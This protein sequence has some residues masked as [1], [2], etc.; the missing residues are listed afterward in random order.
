MQFVEGGFPEPIRMTHPAT[1]NVN[2]LSPHY[3]T[4]GPIGLNVATSRR[5]TYVANT[6]P[7]P[8]IGSQKGRGQ[9]CVVYVPSYAPFLGL[10]LTQLIHRRITHQLQPHFGTL[11]DVGSA[12][13]VAFTDGSC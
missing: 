13:K 8:C 11:S 5:C 4:E 12:R 7:G 10:S 2:L 3:H 1:V 6:T 9:S